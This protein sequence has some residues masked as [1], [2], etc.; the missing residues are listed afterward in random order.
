M[1][2]ALGILGGT[3]GNMVLAAD[4]EITADPIK[5]EGFKIPFWFE[6]KDH[7]V[8][9]GLAITGAGDSGYLE[10][11]SSKL[12]SE[13]ASD[14]MASM[15]Q[16]EGNFQRCLEHFHKVHIFPYLRLPAN[17][18]PEI[19]LIIAAQRDGS[20][21]MWKT[22]KNA[23]LRVHNF[24]ATGIGM[25]QAESLLKTFYLPENS[26]EIDQLIAAYVIFQIKNSVGY[27]G[28]DTD[29]IA[30]GGSGPT[31]E[32]DREVVR[33]YEEV[34]RHFPRIQGR[35]LHSVLGSVYFPLEN[36]MENIF[37]MRKD[38]NAA[39]VRHG[40]G[41]FSRDVLSDSRWERNDQSRRKPSP[42]SLGGIGES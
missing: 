12:Y 24:A 3:L 4:T 7:H 16:L 37:E 27:T 15:D 18:R 21:R 5:G 19:S 40:T 1:T 2:I 22:E 11:I 28:Q 42:E 38:F 20:S 36:V 26:V 10:A 8:T 29:V 14:R 39:I 13:F 33:A 32:L 23:L 41:Q 25:V 35:L 6:G 34:F 17:E 31:M 30:F 9:G